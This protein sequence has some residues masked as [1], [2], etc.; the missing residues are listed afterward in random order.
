[1]TTT[2]QRLY[3]DD[4]GFPSSRPIISVPDITTGL[5]L[6]YSADSL[7]AVGS[8]VSA[9]AST[10]G[11]L[12][13]AADLTGG[14]SSKPVVVAGPNGH[15]AVRFDAASSQYLR[16]AL[17]G[18]PL[19]L[20]LTQVVVMRPTATSTAAVISGHF[21]S[22]SSF[23]GIRRISSGYD[24]G[25]GA[26]GEL[27]NGSSS[28]TSSFHVVTA[29]H[30]SNALLR[31]DTVE[32]AGATGQASPTLATLPRVTIGANSAAN[33][34]FLSGDIVDVR[35]YAR[36]LTNADIASLHA[37]LGAVYGLAA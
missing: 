30:G 23:I 29:R 17:F 10:E 18:T 4:S 15:K 2:V 8:S 12:G 24:A 34:Q 26:T 21:S 37:T 1:M 6:H 22:S 31:V 5:L 7:G 11:S 25:A 19:G 28:D 13:A 20:P 9:W 35:M 3:G 33:G 16:S 32:S 27:V 14:S 36:A